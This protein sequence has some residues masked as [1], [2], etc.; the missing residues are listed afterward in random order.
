MNAHRTQLGAHGFRF[1]RR[2]QLSNILSRH[3]PTLARRGRIV[4]VTLDPAQLQSQ[5]RARVRQR[6]LENFRRHPHEGYEVIDHLAQVPEMRADL[7][8]LA[9]DLWQG[10]Q[11]VLGIKQDNRLRLAIQMGNADALAMALRLA[12]LGDNEAGRTHRL[13]FDL[14]RLLGL[15]APPPNATPADLAPL[16]RRLKVGDFTYRTDKLQWEKKPGIAP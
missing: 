4:E 14:P 13:V 5:Q 12:A 6:L 7:K 2:W 3:A 10:F 8:L 1:L 15:P 11:P 16:Y 9:D